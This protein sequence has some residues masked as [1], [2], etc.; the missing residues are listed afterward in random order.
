ML[1]KMINNGNSSKWRV[2]YYALGRREHFHYP[3][4]VF[5]FY[6]PN[7]CLSGLVEIGPVAP[8]I[9]VFANNKDEHCVSCWNKL[10]EFMTAEKAVPILE[11][12]FS[13]APPLLSEVISSSVEII[14]S[15]KGATHH[16][17]YEKIIA[18][19]EELFAPC[20]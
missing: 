3:I 18:K 8:R 16:E 17:L 13:Q 4:L 2:G 5:F 12:T 11:K 6:N 14:K 15:N 20:S 10:G 7:N 1:Y 19:W 9:Q